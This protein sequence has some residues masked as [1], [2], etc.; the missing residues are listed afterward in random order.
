MLPSRARKPK[1]ILTFRQPGPSLDISVHKSGLVRR[2]CDD[3]SSPAD[4]AEIL[5]LNTKC[6]EA[7]KGNTGWMD[8]CEGVKNKTC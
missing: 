6:N 8:R 3:A 2:V 4:Y 1:N 7:L 5:F